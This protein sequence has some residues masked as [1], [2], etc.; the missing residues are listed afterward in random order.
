M[1]TL[2]DVA[3]GIRANGRALRIPLEELPP[4]ATL[5]M[6]NISGILSAPD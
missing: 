3:A 5:Y 2:R 1:E 6:R 4:E